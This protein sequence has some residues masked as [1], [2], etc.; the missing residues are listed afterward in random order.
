MVMTRRSMDP[1]RLIAAIMPNR[2]P[3]ATSTAMPAAISISV[4]G[5]RA[6]MRVMTSVFWV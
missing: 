4:A 6:M 3:S 5:R 1:P 2:R